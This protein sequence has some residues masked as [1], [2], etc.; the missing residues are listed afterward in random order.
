MSAVHTHSVSVV[1][2]ALAIAIEAHGRQIDK[3]GDPYIYHPLRVMEAC[4]RDAPLGVVA[5]AAVLHDVIEDCEH[6]TL[7]RLATFMPDDVVGAV[8]ALTKRP[9][10]SYDEYVR[11]AASHE[12]AR[13]VKRADAL[14][15][16][17][18]VGEINDP[19]V[20]D[21]LRRKYLRAMELLR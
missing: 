7:E 5:A 13:V 17:A 3:L 20:R 1:S 16:L 11:R 18:R 19:T 2:T 9:S 15:N 12:I 6:W 10:E 14:D 8:C 4:R 21:R